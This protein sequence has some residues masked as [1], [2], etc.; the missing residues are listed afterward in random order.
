MSGGTRQPGDSWL[1][2]TS[3]T[4]NTEDIQNVLVWFSSAQWKK[5]TSN[6]KNKQKNELWSC[7]NPANHFVFC[8]IQETC[9]WTKAKW[10]YLR[11]NVYSNNKLL[12]CCSLAP[13]SRKMSIW[14]RYWGALPVW[15][16]VPV[17]FL[18]QDFSEVRHHDLMLAWSRHKRLV[19]FHSG[20]LVTGLAGSVLHSV[21]WKGNG[22]VS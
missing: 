7:K 4:S 1:S 14:R 20:P 3:S 21:Q 15:A 8:V 13:W 17:E 22:W 12:V 2:Q 10:L 19:G 6:Q 11:N 18:V 5:K 16:A 9:E